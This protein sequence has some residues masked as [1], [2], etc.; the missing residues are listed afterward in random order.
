MPAF[1]RQARSVL[2]CLALLLALTGVPCDAHARQAGGVELRG[3]VI[4]GVT[5]SPVA[6]AAVRLP[7]LRV[8]TLSNAEGWFR[9]PNVPRGRHR[10][11]VSGLGMAP[12]ETWVEAD[13]VTP[14]VLRL[15]PRPLVLEQI[16]VYADFLER[17]A[18]EQRSQ[19]RSFDRDRIVGSGIDDAVDFLKRVGR[20]AIGRCTQTEGLCVLPPFVAMPRPAGGRVSLSRVETMARG[21]P[22]VP[23]GTRM[24]FGDMTVALQPENNQFGN[25]R[26]TATHRIG[27]DPSGR[28][29]GMLDMH[30]TR[31]GSVFLDDVR[32]P[33][34]IND[35]A[36]IR[37]QDIFRVETFGLRGE[38]QIRFY[39]LDYLQRVAAG[40]IRPVMHLEI[41]DRFQPTPPN[42]RLPPPD[43]D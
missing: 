29:F 33:G 24:P 4:D 11:V 15:E 1:P 14:A 2:P 26:M 42:W 40:E 13:G 3:R 17:R 18:R 32:L 36:A 41:D 43:R 37:M 30:P 38:A 25:M 34:G 35:L 19:Y 39:S 9:L 5:G 21:M 10:A 27:I 28:P 22:A 6:G 20:V 7:A 31:A 12:L 8:Y 23:A 16:V